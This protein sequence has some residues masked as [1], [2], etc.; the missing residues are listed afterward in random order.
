LAGRAEAGLHPNFDSG[1]LLAQ[2]IEACGESWCHLPQLDCDRAAVGVY[3]D[4]ALL[5]VGDMRTW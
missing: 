2:L 4:L 3:N 1:N 5:K